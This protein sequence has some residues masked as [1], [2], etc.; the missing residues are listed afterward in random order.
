MPS[1]PNGRTEPRNPGVGVSA[2]RRLA[3]H[4]VQVGS[5][6][7]DPAV[8]ALV[9][10]YRPAGA[11]LLGLGAA[12]PSRD[13]LV[14]VRETKLLI[15]GLAGDGDLDADGRVG[16]DREMEHQHAR[17]DAIGTA[18]RTDARAALDPVQPPVPQD[19]FLGGRFRR[20]AAM[21][22][23]LGAA[24]FEDVGEVR[25]EPK[26]QRHVEPLESVVGDVQTLGQRRRL[27]HAGPGQ[28]QQAPRHQ[29]LVALDHVGVGQIGREHRVVVA[30]RRAEEQR[31]ARAQA[32]LEPRQEAGAAVI[33]PVLAAWRR[34]DVAVEVEDGKAVLVLQHPYRR[35]RAFDLAEDRERAVESRL[36][37]HYA[38]PDTS[39]TPS[40]RD[41][42]S[43]S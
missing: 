29:H 39:G 13:R 2:V 17:L 11:R 42:T 6:A 30:D 43:L 5:R 3:H 31:R 27:D 12:A 10:G 28:V 21:C 20:P 18:H 25:L 22:E 32:Q 35:G 41:L 23:P 15:A 14:E 37:P 34:H 4:H 36:L 24:N 9:R 7:L 19:Y 40:W 26:C 1:R 38:A 33:Q 16:F 8:H